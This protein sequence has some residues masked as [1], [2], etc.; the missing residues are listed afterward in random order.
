MN[1][2]RDGGIEGLGHAQTQCHRREKIVTESE[3]C[4]DKSESLQSRI[5]RFFHFADR[6]TR[7]AICTA[8]SHTIDQAKPEGSPDRNGRIHLQRRPRCAN[9]R[10]A[11]EL[12][13]TPKSIIHLHRKFKF[14]N[15]RAI[16]AAH[17]P[18]ITQQ[19]PQ[20]PVVETQTLDIMIQSLNSVK[21]EILT[22][23]DHGQEKQNCCTCSYHATETFMA[24]CDVCNASFM[25][26]GA[27]W[28]NWEAVRITRKS[29]MIPRDL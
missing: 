26:S 16:S 18:S 5:R 17:G 9:L 6:K 23:K 22:P 14:R 28:T 4:S 1:T 19:H 3:Q 2:L 21:P 20:T 13:V 15:L 8:T 12:H 7:L 10:A 29:H 27:K 24:V 11:S 25:P